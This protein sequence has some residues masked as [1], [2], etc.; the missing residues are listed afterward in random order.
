MTTS[1]PGA[2][3]HYRKTHWGWNWKCTGQDEIT[4]SVSWVM[5]L[6]KPRM[7][8]AFSQQPDVTVDA[9]IRYDILRHVC[10]FDTSC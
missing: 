10:S 8:F 6:P 7:L 9:W 5:I 1:N 2:Y 4:G 3:N